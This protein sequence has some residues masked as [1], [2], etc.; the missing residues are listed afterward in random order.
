MIYSTKK[1]APSSLLLILIQ[2]SLTQNADRAR[3]L[4]DVEEVA[5]KDA[6]VRKMTLAAD[7]LD[8][9]V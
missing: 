8:E 9:A 3:S 2:R 6:I 4:H 5:K 1:P 7:A